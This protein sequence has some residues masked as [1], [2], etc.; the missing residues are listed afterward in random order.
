MYTTLQYFLKSYCTLSIHED[1]IVGVMEEFL[2]Q[3]D[4]EIVLKLRDEL[5]YMKKKSAWEEACVLVA[6]QGNRMWSLEETK[7]H[8]EAFLLLLQKKKA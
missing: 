5:L 3:E 2:E 4:E 1:E 7:D 8:L 6:K